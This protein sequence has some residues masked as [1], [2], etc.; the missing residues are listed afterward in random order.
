M[1][2]RRGAQPATG[3]AAAHIAGGMNTLLVQPGLI[4]EAAGI[5]ETMRRFQAHRELPGFTG[6]YWLTVVPAQLQPLWKRAN[7]TPGAKSDNI[8]DKPLHGFVPGRN[9]PDTY[10]NNGI[11]ARKALGQYVLQILRRVDLRPA[12][13]KKEYRER[14]ARTPES[15]VSQQHRK[16]KN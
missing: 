9:V 6:A 3:L 16:Q 10:I 14:T 5:H 12:H 7:V 11:F 2:Q 8:D 1:R 15:A 4:I 13:A